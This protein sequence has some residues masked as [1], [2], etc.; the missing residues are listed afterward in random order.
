M[1]V[2]F[3]SNNQIISIVPPLTTTVCTLTIAE[4]II[5]FHTRNMFQP[6]NKSLV[7]L[8]RG[9]ENMSLIYY[10]YNLHPRDMIKRHSP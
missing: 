2:W 1:S 3:S 5:M 6:S 9:N 8:T 7:V 10:K 4:S